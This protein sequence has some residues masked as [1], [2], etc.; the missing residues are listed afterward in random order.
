ME[1]PCGYGA[2]FSDLEATAIAA[3]LAIERLSEEHAVVGVASGSTP[4]EPGDLVRVLPNHACPVSNLVDCVRLVEG[5]EVVDTLA[6][7][8]RGRIT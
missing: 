5:R 4:L 6:V 3:D 7:A 1:R 8:A 2:V